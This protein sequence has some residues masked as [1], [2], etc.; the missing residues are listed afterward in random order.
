MSRTISPPFEFKF[1]I[2]SFLDKMFHYFDIYDYPSGIA[3][4]VSEPQV[5]TQIQDI[6]GKDIYVG[7]ILEVRTRKPMGKPEEGFSVRYEVE[8]KRDGFSYCF[9][10]KTDNP[11]WVWLM[12]VNQGVSQHGAKVV[13]HI[14]DEDQSKKTQQ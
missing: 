14:F 5:F 13:G 1:R 8:L 12:P 7:D 11:I 2:Y 4:G 10:M 6:D 9:I 3:G